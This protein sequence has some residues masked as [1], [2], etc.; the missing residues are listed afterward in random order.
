[1]YITSLVL[2][3]NNSLV[4]VLQPSGSTSSGCEESAEETGMGLSEEFIEVATT[5]HIGKRQAL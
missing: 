1:M 4:L 3:M 2:S 5:Q